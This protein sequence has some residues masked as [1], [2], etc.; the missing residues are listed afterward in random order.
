[1]HKK[2][3]FYK[4]GVISRKTLVLFFLPQVCRFLHPPFLPRELFFLARSYLLPAAEAVAMAM[5]GG[6]DGFFSSIRRLCQGGGGGGGAKGVL[7]ALSC[8]GGD[9]P[10]DSTKVAGKKKRPRWCF[11]SMVSLFFARVVTDTC[12]GGHAMFWGS[13]RKNI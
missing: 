2:Y 12:W 8:K 11:C 10:M 6:L 3:F 1:M 9:A 5:G 7:I 13:E 4:T